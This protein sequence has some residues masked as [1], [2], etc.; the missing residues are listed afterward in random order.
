MIKKLE[1]RGVKVSNCK[2]V[3]RSLKEKMCQISQDYHFEMQQKEDPMDYED[4]SYE[5]PN[6]D[7]IQ[8]KH[9]ERLSSTEIIFDPSLIISHNCPPGIAQMA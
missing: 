7:I 9:T 2:E 4:R 3:I 1:H 6:G 5:L 8:V